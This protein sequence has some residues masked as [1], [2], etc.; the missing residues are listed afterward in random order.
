MPLNSQNNTSFHLKVWK[1]N[2]DL[3]SIP[4]TVQF[5]ANQLYQPMEGKEITKL[6][7]KNS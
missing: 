3:H 4:D 5:Y 6:T 2:F 7:N 1:F